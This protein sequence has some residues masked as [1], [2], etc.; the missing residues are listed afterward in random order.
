MGNKRS[1]ALKNLQKS[2]TTIDG[3][4]DNVPEDNSK[5]IAFV[6]AIA[7]LPPLPDKHDVDALNKRLDEYLSLCDEYGM[8]VGNIACYTALG[9]PKQ[10]MWRWERGED[11]ARNDSALRDFAKRVKN[12]CGLYR[13]TL[14]QDGKI[15]PV[16]GIFWQ[17][18][19][20]GLRDQQEYVV[21]AQNP[22]G[23]NPSRKQIEDRFTAD[24]TEVDENGES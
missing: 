3:A 5:R 17:K 19:Y 20:D 13:E 21:A 16:T 24:F 2:C 10:T 1:S 18:N 11:G 7:A 9:I 12:L 15:N 8:K 23:D 22:L 6:K 14:M 4:I